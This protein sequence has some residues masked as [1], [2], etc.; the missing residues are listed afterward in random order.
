MG[1]S[2]KKSA[3]MGRGRPRSFDSDRALEQA[4]RVFWQRGYAGTSLSDLTKAMRI[5]RP[6]LYAAFGDKEALFRKALDRYAAERE[7]YVQGALNQSS[8]FEV[9]KALLTG[10]ADSMCGGGQHPAGCLLVQGALA[11]GEDNE[12]IRREL[13]LR[14]RANEVLICRRMQRAKEEGDLPMNAEP[15][16]LARYLATLTQG[17]AVQAAGGATREQLMEI[18]K[19]AL[20]AW[21]SE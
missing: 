13:A 9:A 15:A 14:R 5:N 3:S 12:M 20:L 8:A 18:A 7:S 10:A 19:T 21:P 1:K 16:V 17:M 2:V 6:S 4:L 11:T